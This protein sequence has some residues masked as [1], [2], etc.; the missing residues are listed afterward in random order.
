M[1]N[2]HKEIEERYYVISKYLEN[3]GIEVEEVKRK[4]SEFKVQVPT[5]V[6]G[7]FGGGRFS[8]YIPPGAATNVFEKFDDAAMVNKL[9]GLTPK[10]S[11]HVGWDDPDRAS[12]CDIN[13]RSFKRLEDYAKT[14]GVS[15]GSVNI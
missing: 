12:F 15:I 13:S 7:S 3:I 11:I 9:T 2:C 8:G 14:V 4:L 6:F 1:L 5:W 10:V